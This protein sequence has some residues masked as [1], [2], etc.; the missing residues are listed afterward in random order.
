MDSAQSMLR[1]ITVLLSQFLFRCKLQRI[2]LLI[3]LISSRVTKRLTLSFLQITIPISRMQE[4][5]G[6]VVKDEV[7]E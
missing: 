2:W 5:L 4:V 7:K 6:A 3:H 1:N